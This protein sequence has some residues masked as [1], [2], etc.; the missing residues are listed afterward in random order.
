MYF[1]ATEV[2]QNGQIK[3][4][5]EIIKSMGLSAGDFVALIYENGRVIMRKLTPSESKMTF[6]E[7]LLYRDV[8]VRDAIQERVARLLYGYLGSVTGDNR[9][10]PN[11]IGHLLDIDT[12]ALTVPACCFSNIFED[13]PPYR[14]TDFFIRLSNDGSGRSD[15]RIYVY[16][17]V[18]TEPL[19]CLQNNEYVIFMLSDNLIG[20]VERN[21]NRH[22]YIK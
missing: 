3:L 15:I 1:R 7:F 5:D 11:L 9:L 16:G 14:D 12:S 2:Q 17:K 6:E 20:C 13:T 10:L 21:I 8:K 19:R 4:S 18:M 22:I